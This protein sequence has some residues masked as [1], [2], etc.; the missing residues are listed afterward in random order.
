MFINASFFFI[1]KGD[2]FV[3]EGRISGF[4]DVFINRWKQPQGII[5][6]VGRMSGFLAVRG[7]FRSVLM[8][9]MVCKFDQGQPAPVATWAESIKRIFSFAIS[10]ARWMIP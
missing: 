4:G 3:K 5:G 1:G 6:A 8:A 2:N 9:R 7:V 10:G